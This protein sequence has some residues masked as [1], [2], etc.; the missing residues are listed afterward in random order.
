MSV[1]AEIP[2]EVEPVTALEAW[3]ASTP[4]D[5]RWLRSVPSSADDAA[6]ADATRDDDGPSPVATPRLAIVVAPSRSAGGRRRDRGRSEQRQRRA[7][8][9]IEAQRIAAR[10]AARPHLPSPAEVARDVALALFEVEAGRRSAVQ[11]ERVCSPELWG[12]LEHQV[13]RDGGLVP[14]MSD[15]LR[16]HFQEL[17]PGLASTVALVQRGP[18]VQPVAMLLDAC[19]GRWLVT[20]LRY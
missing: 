7:Q 5:G 12:I 18:R 20:E 16:V 15:L 9:V 14:R 8:E 1:S 13:R 2:S 10:R 3:Q 6:A 19:S 11:L 17:V 4:S